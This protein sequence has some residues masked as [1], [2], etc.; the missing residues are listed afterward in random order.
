MS[1]GSGHLPRYM[2][3]YF[4]DNVVDYNV[5]KHF[6]QTC[7]NNVMGEI[8]LEL[9]SINPF[10]QD[11]CQRLENLHKEICVLIK[12]KHDLD[13]CHFNDAVQTVVTVIFKTVDGEPP[14][15]KK[16]KKKKKKKK[17]WFH[18][19]KLMVPLKIS[20]LVS[21]LDPLVHYFFQM[22]M[23]GDALIFLIMC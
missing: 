22:V 8:S 3:L 6:N 19:H 18:F 1:D 7:N 11:H 5:H 21:S 14:F 4:Y 13:Q 16:K 20:V 23:L 17:T 9:D 10:V 12:L 15:W 2:Q